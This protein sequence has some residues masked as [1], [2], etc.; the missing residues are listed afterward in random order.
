MTEM[1]SSG[2]TSHDTVGGV[3][4]LGSPDNGIHDY[5]IVTPS[6]RPYCYITLI[7]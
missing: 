2:L 3:V 7:S 1:V 6:V 4:L 5:C